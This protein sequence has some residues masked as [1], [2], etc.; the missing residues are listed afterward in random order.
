MRALLFV[1]RCLMEPIAEKA[2]S[3]LKC[4]LAEG[5]WLYSKAL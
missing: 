1:P 2:E 4:G 3:V 5:D